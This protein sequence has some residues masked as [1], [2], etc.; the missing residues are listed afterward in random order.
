MSTPKVCEMMRAIRRQPNRGLRDLSSTMARMRASFGPVGPGFFGYGLDE[1]KSVVLATHQR[2]IKRQERRG[3]YA[4]GELADSSW[5]EEKRSESADQP[6]AQRQLRPPLASSAQDD[7][8]LLEHELLRDHRSRATRV[9]Q[10][11]GHDG[12]VE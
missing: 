12:Q 3:S 6:G 9:T 8:L 2:L 10:L 7:Q 1:N 11:R 5:T 4:D